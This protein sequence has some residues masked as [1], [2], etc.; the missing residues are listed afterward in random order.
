M[1]P[2]TSHGSYCSPPRQCSGTRWDSWRCYI[3]ST[4]QCIP[5][6]ASTASVKIEHRQAIAEAVAALVPEN[7]L[8][9]DGFLAELVQ[10]IAALRAILDGLPSQDNQAFVQALNEVRGHL[11]EIYR[12][13]RRILKNCRS[14]V[15]GLTPERDGATILGYRS[16]R[17]GLLAEAVERWRSEAANV[18]YGREDCASS[19]EIANWHAQLVGALLVQ[20]LHSLRRLLTAPPPGSPPVE[21]LTAAASEMSD[22]DSR[23]RT[24]LQA[25]KEVT[26]G[27][28]CVL[29]CTIASTADKV[30]RFLR[31]HL[32]DTVARSGL[33]ASR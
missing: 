28:K 21:A 10:R 19:R 23:E 27:T 33:A 15:T 25:L 7:L 13:D 18:I 31:A 14:S 8:Q 17:T 30:G 6:T 26:P 11:S 20:D 5:S 29:F 32:K 2:G 22:D 9:L 24:L 12:L 1:R 16:P 3:S 4:R